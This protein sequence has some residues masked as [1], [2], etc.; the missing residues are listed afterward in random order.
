[1]GQHLDDRKIVAGGTGEDASVHQAER[2]ADPQRRRPPDATV[3][4][5]HQA[6]VGIDHR[7]RAVHDVIADAGV[8]RNHGEVDLLLRSKSRRAGR[9]VTIRNQSERQEDQAECNRATPSHRRSH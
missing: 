7:A 8:D 6:A 3:R 9:P 4:G 5:E 1:M 2:R